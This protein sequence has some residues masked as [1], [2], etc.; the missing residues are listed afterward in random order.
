MNFYI[1]GNSLPTEITPSYSQILSQ[2]FNVKIYG[3][4]NNP[5][6]GCVL[7][8]IDWK[9]EKDSV[10]I[11]HAGCAEL[12]PINK[13][14]NMIW[15]NN[16]WKSLDKDNPEISYFEETINRYKEKEGNNPYMTEDEFLESCLIARTL[17]NKIEVDKKI[18]VG[19][20]YLPENEW[21]Y[22]YMY[23]ANKIIKDIFEDLIYIDMYKEELLYLVHYDRIHFTTEGHKYMCREILERIVK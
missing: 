17:L 3:V 2:D 20:N 4:S 21:R 7:K 18:I 23:K 22:E 11:I 9:V 13:N 16:V 6:I 12:I 14:S 15:L 10:V 19:V 1:V 8:L 5:I